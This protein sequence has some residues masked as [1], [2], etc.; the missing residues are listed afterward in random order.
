MANTLSLDDVNNIYAPSGN[1]VISLA[2]RSHDRGWRS[3]K[4]FSAESASK[5]I[6]R[7]YLRHCSVGLNNW[8]NVSICIFECLCCCMHCVTLI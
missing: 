8:V 7:H 1:C 2:I 4:L 3:D 6:V 5:Q